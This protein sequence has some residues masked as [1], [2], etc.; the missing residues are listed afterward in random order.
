MCF[1]EL[2]SK[3]VYQKEPRCAA[4]ACTQTHAAEYVHPGGTDWCIQAIRRPRWSIITSVTASWRGDGRF[5]LIQLFGWSAEVLN[6]AASTI[7]AQ[8]NQCRADRAKIRFLLTTVQTSC[9]SLHGIIARCHSSPSLLNSMRRFGFS[10]PAETPF[11][12]PLK[13]DPW[14]LITCSKFNVSYTESVTHVCF[15]F[16]FSISSFI[17]SPFRSLPF[18]PCDYLPHPDV[19]HLCL[20][21]FPLLEYLVSASSSSSLLISLIRKS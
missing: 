1:P 18:L 2:S 21:V 20:I 10:P 3:D 4:H 9:C 8:N 19:V 5:S 12:S 16:Q 6:S 17:L 15:P 7:T 11:H 14:S 13:K